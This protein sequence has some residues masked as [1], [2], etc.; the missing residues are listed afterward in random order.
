[1][2]AAQAYILILIPHST[3]TI[4]G[5]FQAIPALLD[6]G[7]SNV[8][9]ASGLTQVISDL[10]KPAYAAAHGHQPL[11]DKVAAGRAQ[12]T[13]MG[14]SHDQWLVNDPETAALQCKRS[15]PRP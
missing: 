9:K 4:F 11:K 7:R 15:E 13:S 10:G 2:R 6:D 14:L 8:A 1:L 12:G 5:A 3:S